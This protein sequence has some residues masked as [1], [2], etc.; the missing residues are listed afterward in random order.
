V[1]VPGDSAELEQVDMN[2]REHRSAAE[3]FEDHLRLRTANDAETDILTNYAEDVVLLTCTGVFRG[4]DGVRAS[5]EEL[6]K[7]FPDGCYTYVRK[8]VDGEVAF[9][10][11]TGQSPVGEVRD[12]ADSFVIRNGKIVAQ[13]IHYMVDRSERE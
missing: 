2:E 6:K 4:H 5:A 9:L 1:T 12:G 11:W 10:V 7:Y 3:V 8:V 13:T